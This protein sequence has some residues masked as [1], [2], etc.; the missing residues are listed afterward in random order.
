MFSKQINIII[1]K[2]ITQIANYITSQILL[3]SWISIGGRHIDDIISIC[4][5]FF[6]IQNRWTLCCHWS[7]QPSV[8]QYWTNAWHEIYMINTSYYA[9]SKENSNSKRALHPHLF[10]LHSNLSAGQ[11][12]HKNVAWPNYALRISR[13]AKYS[14][15]STFLLLWWQL[16][17]QQ[18]QEN[19]GA[20]QKWCHKWV[21][22][23]IIVTRN[24][25]ILEESSDCM[26]LV[27]L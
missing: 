25:Q 27:K 22:Q 8:I 12:C 14:T 13:L 17:S 24:Y 7:V 6:I 21:L 5:R 3:T 1:H 11:V 26:K 10:C 18:I 20:L 23:I 19:T 16:K 4:L 9:F 15:D 2:N